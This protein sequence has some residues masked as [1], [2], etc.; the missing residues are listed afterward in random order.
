[1]TDREFLIW[2]HQRLVK[3]YGESEFMDH[4]HFLREIIHATD[5][6]KRSIGEVVTMDSSIVLKEIDKLE[7]KAENDDRYAKK[8]EVQLR[9]GA[10]NHKPLNIQR[11]G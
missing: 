8:L 3:V 6:D 5:K 4:M 9:R 1:M 11:L 7:G 10:R 2:L